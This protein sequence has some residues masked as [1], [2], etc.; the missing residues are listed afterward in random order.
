MSNST[1]VQIDSWPKGC[2]KSTRNPDNVCKFVDDKTH[3]GLITVE[4]EI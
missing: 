2:S 4:V 3:G 1:E